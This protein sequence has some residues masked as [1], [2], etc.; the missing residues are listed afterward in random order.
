MSIGSGRRLIALHVIHQIHKCLTPTQ[1]VKIKLT[2][3][4]EAFLS[5][6]KKLVWSERNKVQSNVYQE[7]TPRK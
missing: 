6:K 2:K 1:K 4:S 5:M 3:A 7:V